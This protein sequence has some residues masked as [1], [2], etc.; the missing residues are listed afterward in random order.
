MF[1]RDFTISLLVGLNSTS[2]ASGADFSAP[3]V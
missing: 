3:K 2:A 1:F